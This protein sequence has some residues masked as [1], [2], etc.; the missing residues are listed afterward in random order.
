MGLVIFFKI[1]TPW[2]I[3]CDSETGQS[4]PKNKSLNLISG[5]QRYKGY[6]SSE[7][8]QECDRK[9]NNSEKGKSRTEMNRAQDIVRV[10][11][12]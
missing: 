7:K 10:F 3:N 9:Y 1:H 4:R 12:Q 6:Q 8:R 11:S 5:V 2:G